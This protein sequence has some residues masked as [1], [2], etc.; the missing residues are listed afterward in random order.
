MFIG[1]SK[2]LIRMGSFRI[3]AGVRLGKWAS[4]A[5]MIFAAIFYLMYFSILLCLWAIYGTCYVCF[6]L[7]Y[8][9]IKKLI[10]HT[11]NTEIEGEQHEKAT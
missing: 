4:I 3:G 8:L 1:I 6:Y 2:T 10:Q 5:F 7:P 11:K 9:G